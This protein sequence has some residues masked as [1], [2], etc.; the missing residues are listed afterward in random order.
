MAGDVRGDQRLLTPAFVLLGIA[1]L[2]YFTSVG[3]V[4]HTLPLYTTGPVGSNEA[5]AG[6]AFGAFAITALVCRPFAGRLS[7][8]RGRLPLMVLGAVL[9]AIGC[10]LMPVTDSLAEIVVLRLLQGVGEAAF[11]VAGI[12]LLIDIAPP[13]RMG[14]ALSTTRSASTSAS[15]SVRRSARCCWRG[16][17]STRRGTA[18]PCSR[19]WRPG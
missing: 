19:W 13:A 11:F 10:V 9:A 18:P 8:R 4:I 3:V 6:L 14:E 15:P 17:A 1:D 16:G 5:G 7:D 2:A 12:A